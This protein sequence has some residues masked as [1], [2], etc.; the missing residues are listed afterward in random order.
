MTAQAREAGFTLVEV[1]V[2]VTVF[3]VISAIS[4]GLLTS[5]LRTREAHQAAMAEIGQLQRARA[6]LREDFGQ[7]VARAGKT[8]D[9]VRDPVVL[10]ADPSG[11]DRAGLRSPGRSEGDLVEIVRFTRAGWANP[12]GF[13]PRSTLQTVAYLYDGEQ[14]VRRAWAYPDPAPETDY[15]DRIILEEAADLV[16]EFRAGNTWV[17]GVRLSV[18]EEGEAADPPPAVRLRYRS[19]RLGEVEHV[20]LTPAAE[21]T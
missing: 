9:G 4:V 12:G 13:S 19:R 8:A 10:E 5:A 7:L 2:A 15:S 11:V 3:S 1:L 6:V 14:L 17:D 18:N 16:F 21:A 20:A